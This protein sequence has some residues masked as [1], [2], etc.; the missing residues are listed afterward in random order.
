MTPEKYTEWAKHHI[1]LFAL[2]DPSDVRLLT[3]WAPRLM[4][5]E[6]EELY[7]ASYAV[8]ED[9]SDKKR[10]RENHLEMLRVAVFV[11]RAEAS[12]LE[13][14]RLDR[15]Y[16]RAEC[17]D[18]FAVGLIRVPHP[19]WIVDGELERPVFMVVACH[20]PAGVAKFNAVAARLTE[21]QAKHKIIDLA[22]Y[23]ALHPDWRTILAAR[24]EALT[25]EFDVAELARKVD[26]ASPIDPANIGG[27]KS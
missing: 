5:F 7:A 19:G 25:R 26:N 1:D 3:L 6:F 23:E 12:A 10:Y 13:R 9:P 2:R 15:L 27:K 4:Q 14:D 21:S 24:Q 20:C 18:C 16:S 8:D 11:K 17:G 22:E